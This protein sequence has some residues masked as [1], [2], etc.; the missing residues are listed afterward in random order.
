[1]H[2]RQAEDSLTTAGADPDWLDFFDPA[3]LAGFSGY[4]QLVAGRAREAASSLE[5]ALAQL[6][7]RA[8]K[9]RSVVLLDLATSYAPTDP[10][11]AMALAEQ[12]FDQLEHQPYVTAHDRIPALRRA[13]EGT[14]QARVFDERAR[15]FPTIAI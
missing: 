4:S 9:Q 14:P 5:R 2:A 6:D 3:R 7:D 11:Y 13:L 12:A 8:G 10:E 15:A 1:R